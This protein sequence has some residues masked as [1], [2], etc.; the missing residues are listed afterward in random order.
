MQD[1]NLNVNLWG[2]SVN[3]WPNISLPCTLSEAGCQSTST[4]LHAYTRE[5]QDKWLFAIREQF[6]G[7]MIK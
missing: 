4:D 3:N 2:G 6:E 7:K 1:K 5:K